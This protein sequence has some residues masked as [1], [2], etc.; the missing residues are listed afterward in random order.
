MAISS[1]LPY[2]PLTIPTRC[3]VNRC[4]PLSL[5]ANT[6]FMD[7][8]KIIRFIN[9]LSLVSKQKTWGFF[10]KRV[11]S[12][13]FSTVSNFATEPVISFWVIHPQNIIIN[14]KLEKNIFFIILKRSLTNICTKIIFA[15][16]YIHY[17]IRIRLVSMPR[18]W[19]KNWRLNLIVVICAR[20]WVGA[21]MPGKKSTRFRIV[22]TF[23]GYSY[24]R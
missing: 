1:M 9:A 7:L 21:A 12:T 3:M 24:Y 4:L 6:C 16:D 8:S 11:S 17:Y 23:K 14:R 19:I 2:S 13:T 5:K 20:Q 10:R 15:C 18:Y 22:L